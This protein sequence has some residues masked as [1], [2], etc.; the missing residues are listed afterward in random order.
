[1]RKFL[2]SLWEIAEVLVIA[3]ISIF[4]IYGFIAQPFLVQGASMEPTF[5]NGNYLVIDEITYRFRSPERGEVIVFRNPTNEAEFYIKRIIGLPSEEI[6]IAGDKVS[7][8]GTELAE[9]YLPDGIEFDNNLSVKLKEDQY[10]V[11]GDNRARSYD[12]RSWGP[13]T[14]GEIIG[15]VRIRFWP[16]LDVKFFT[17]NE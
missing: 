13:L 17:N 5:S 7:I 11:M 4:I 9:E 6:K 12:S 8:N 2:S 3:S 10:F 14:R 16:P 15:A 1:M